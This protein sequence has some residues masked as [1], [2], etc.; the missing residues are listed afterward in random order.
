MDTF[1]PIRS[2]RTAQSELEIIKYTPQSE[3]SIHRLIGE[4]SNCIDATAKHRCI[5]Q[6]YTLLLLYISFRGCLW[7]YFCA[8]RQAARIHSPVKQQRAHVWARGCLVFYLCCQIGHM[9]CFSSLTWLKVAKSGWKMC[10]IWQHGRLILTAKMIPRDVLFL[11]E[12]YP[13]RSVG[14][15]LR[16]KWKIITGSLI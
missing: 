8:K 14:N 2:G 16:S 7:N 4:R 5:S 3:W 11:E 9:S 13:H 6:Y 15:G 12:N 1:D 10:P